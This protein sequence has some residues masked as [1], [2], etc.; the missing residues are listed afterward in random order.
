M[1]MD[2][3]PEEVTEMTNTNDKWFVVTVQIGWAAGTKYDENISVGAADFQQAADRAEQ[4]VHTSIDLTEG[5]GQRSA[6][7]TTVKF[8]G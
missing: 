6:V 5:A 7:A 1:E 3:R 2:N 4:E 8:K